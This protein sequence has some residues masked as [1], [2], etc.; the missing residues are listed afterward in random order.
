METEF[1]QTDGS[2]LLG[3]WLVEPAALRIHRDNE[4]VKLEPKVMDV[5]V[6]LARHP[7][8]VVSRESLE[9]DVW[10]GMIVGYDAL[11]S[12]IIKLRKALQ[13][14]SR[15]PRYIETI[16]KKGYRLLA[17]VR[18]GE[19]QH[20]DHLATPAA[21]PNAANNDLAIAIK[22]L[23]RQRLAIAVMV[24]CLLFA[25]FYLMQSDSKKSTSQI[26]QNGSLPSLVVLPFIN[27]N[28]DPSQEYFSDGITDDLINDLSGYGN[29]RVIAR[30]SAYAYKDRSVAM[31]II[32]R[33]LSVNYIL[34]GNIRR[35][36][37]TIRLNVQLIEA[38]NG[39]ILWAQRFDKKIIDIFKVQ[40]EIR[41]RIVSALS[42]TLTQQEQLRVQ[43]RYS[44]SFEAYDMFLKGQARLVTRASA[45]DNYAAQS[46]MEK[47]I[48]FDP[49]FARAYS[50][51]ALL[52]A[53]AYRFDWSDNP[54]KSR[55][56]A[57]DA[58]QRA[59]ELDN[60]SPQ[61]LWILGYVYLFLF[62]D[63]Q[64]A[65][66]MSKLANQLAP[67]DMDAENVLAVTYV[68]NG[69]PAR[70]KLIIQELMKHH[71]TYSAMVPSVLGQANFLIG[72]Y[73]EALAALNESLLINPSRI[74]PNVYKILTLYRLGELE[75]AQFQA[76]Q[77][78]ILHPKFD[79]KAW[80]AKQPFKDKSAVNDMLHDLVNIGVKN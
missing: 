56:L 38:S 25:A 4:D 62:Q 46:Y 50:A 48:E 29:L 63:Y 66:E 2:F 3:D 69:D 26:A 19:A 71:Q 64:K 9:K 10:S 44:N 74:N 55:Q 11:T 43:R 34:D 21:A 53:D 65:I 14:S 33:D 24:I 47:A 5:L 18:S 61:A 12:T 45:A 68:Y 67:H 60:S 54:L 49:S 30:R 13:D 6:Y 52:H 36:N 40:D 51:L 80:A 16:P 79:A 22:L 7:A 58:G 15:N 28:H 59:L 8:Q 57:L 23:S 70:A 77:L 27:L 17:E 73:N 39:A 76:Q 31:N 20:R 32:A 72:H 35:E 42:L 37:D 41:Q 75:D 1:A 78:F